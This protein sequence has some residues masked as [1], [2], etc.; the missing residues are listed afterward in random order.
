MSEVGL[1]HAHNC[2]PK[3]KSGAL[4]ENTI[5]VQKGYRSCGWSI[6]DPSI[7]LKSS[8][9]TVLPINQKFFK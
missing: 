1:T 9:F 5:H 3:L 7:K 8:K 6:L 4:K 2:E